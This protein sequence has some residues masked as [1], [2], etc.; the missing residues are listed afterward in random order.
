[1][2]DRFWVSLFM[3]SLAIFLLFVF[4]LTAILFCWLCWSKPKSLTEAFRSL[5]HRSVFVGD[6]IQASST[7]SRWPPQRE[8]HRT[9]RSNDVFNAEGKIKREAVAFEGGTELII[10]GWW[11]LPAW[12]IYPPSPPSIAS[13]SRCSFTWW[14]LKS[15]VSLC[16]NHDSIK[17]R[18]RRWLKTWCREIWMSDYS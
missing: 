1:M 15:S 3:H 14:A 16:E 2:A 13:Y 18:L 12:F 6:L 10:S 8:A 5:S 17:K 9:H 11:L 7:R 4:P